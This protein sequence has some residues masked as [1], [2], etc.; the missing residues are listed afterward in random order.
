MTTYKLVDPLKVA[1]L[2]NNDYTKLYLAVDMINKGVREKDLPPDL[3]AFVYLTIRKLGV[4]VG[5]YSH[6]YVIAINLRAN[7]LLI[8]RL[9]ASMSVWFFGS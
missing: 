4:K 2:N 7:K 1:Q 5:S 8:E 3:Y 6:I 9:R